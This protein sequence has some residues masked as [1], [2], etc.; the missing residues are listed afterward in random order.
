MTNMTRVKIEM[1]NCM[2]LNNQPPALCN[3]VFNMNVYNYL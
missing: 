3:I 2:Q 1:E